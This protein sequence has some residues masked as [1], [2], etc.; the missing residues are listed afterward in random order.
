MESGTR[1]VG[2]LDLQTFQRFFFIPLVQNPVPCF[3]L[4]LTFSDVFPLRFSPCLADDPSCSSVR[5]P[6]PL[7][8]HSEAIPLMIKSAQTIGALPLLDEVSIPG[9]RSHVAFS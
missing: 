5:S 7:A 1:Q 8:D 4:F 6:S 3:Q 9:P 2:P